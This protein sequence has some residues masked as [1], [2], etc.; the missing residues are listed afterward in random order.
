MMAVSFTHHCQMSGWLSGKNNMLWKLK[1][2]FYCRN[3]YILYNKGAYKGALH[4][5]SFCN[6]LFNFGRDKDGCKLYSSLPHEWLAE[7]K[8]PYIV[9]AQ[10]KILS[11]QFL[12]TLH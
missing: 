10:Q 5:A 6:I 3:T 11:P 7:W 9:E 8:K 1:K 2:K 4:F 12:Y